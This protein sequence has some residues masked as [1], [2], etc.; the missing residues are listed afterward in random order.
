MS[1]PEHRANILNGDFRDSGV[2]VA[3]AAPAMCGEGLPGA[4]YTQDFG[5][6]FSY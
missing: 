2:G 3:P 1:S 6:V 5:V 4:T